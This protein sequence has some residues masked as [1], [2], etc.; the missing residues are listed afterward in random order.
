MEKVA[1]EIAPIRS[2]PIGVDSITSNAHPEI[3]SVKGVLTMVN[4]VGKVTG[5]PVGFEAVVKRLT[6]REQLPR[7]IAI[8][9]ILLP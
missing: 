4:W 9:Q 5:K 3:K 8:R 2:I 1:E 7:V 6:C